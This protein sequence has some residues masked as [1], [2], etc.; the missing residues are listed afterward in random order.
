[1]VGL[2]AYGGGSPD[3][4]WGWNLGFE[5]RDLA[6]GDKRLGYRLIHVVVFIRRKT[7]YEVDIRLPVC[8]VLAACVKSGIVGAWD[9]GN[10]EAFSL[11]TRKLHSFAR[12]SD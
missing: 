6:I 9:G 4:G 1:M 2:H 10:K 3:I 11:G 8:E 12:L 7:V 5:P